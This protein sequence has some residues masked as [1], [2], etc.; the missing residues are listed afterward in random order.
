MLRALTL[1]AILLLIA[2]PKVSPLWISLASWHDLAPHFLDG[3][4]DLFNPWLRHMDF[5]TIGCGASPVMPVIKPVSVDAK[6]S[7]RS[8]TIRSTFHAS[9]CWAVGRLTNSSVQ[10]GGQLHDP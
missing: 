2:V 1:A 7:F 5:L 6:V 9:R 10:S 8:V 3:P 4:D